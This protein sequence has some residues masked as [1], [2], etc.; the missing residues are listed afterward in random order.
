MFQK[1]WG[2]ELS[3]ILELR[4]GTFISYDVE[5]FF[6]D[7]LTHTDQFSAYPPSRSIAYTPMNIYYAWLAEGNDETFHSAVKQSVNQFRAV[8]IK[9]GQQIEQA[10]LYTN[11]AIYDTPLEVMYGDNL[12]RLRALKKLHDPDNVMGLAGGFKF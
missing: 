7:I 11:Y 4:T 2:R 3:N 1:F 9:E 12:P 8:A 5:P 6:S 10:P